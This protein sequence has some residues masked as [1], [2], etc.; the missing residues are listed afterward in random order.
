MDRAEEARREPVSGRGDRCLLGDVAESDVGN[1][2]TAFATPTAMA[3]L[4]NRDMAGF[5]RSRG[6]TSTRCTYRSTFLGCTSAENASSFPAALTTMR[7]DARG[8][9]AVLRSEPP[10]GREAASAAT[11]PAMPTAW[12]V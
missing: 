6:K 11:T 1:L 8:E 5:F 10:C 2:P 4:R 12:R 9:L 7:G 3:A